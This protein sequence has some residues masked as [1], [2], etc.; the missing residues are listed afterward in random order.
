M[1]RTRFSGP[2]KSS[3]GFEIGTGATNTAVI[4]SSGSYIKAS[5]IPT[6][7]LTNDS[8]TSAKLVS[9]AAPE[10]GVLAV[11]ST[12]A[13]AVGK[14][15]YISSWSTLAGL[16]GRPKVTMAKSDLVTRKPAE[17]VV[18]TA[19]TAANKGCTIARAATITGLATS[20]AAAVGAPVVLSSTAAGIHVY[21]TLAPVLKNA[22]VQRLGVVTVKA[23]AASGGAIRFFVGDSKALTVTATT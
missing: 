7:S 3:N 15:V 22:F 10:K 1:A 20:A 5:G 16:T 2:L 18:I 19:S 23:V 8:I 4:D 6:G 17:Y 11:S 12:G 14:L 9:E 21:S 13:Y